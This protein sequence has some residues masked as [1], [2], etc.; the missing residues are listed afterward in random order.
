MNDLKEK[1]KNG[2]VFMEPSFCGLCHQRQYQ[3][4][5]GSS[6][7]YAAESP[8]FNT[9]E[10]VARRVLDGAVANNGRLKNFCNRCHTPIGEILG[11]LTDYVDDGSVTPMRNGLS[12]V[13]RRGIFCETCHRVSAIDTTHDFTAGRLGDGIA[14][15]S[16]I[17]EAT[18]RLRRGPL[19]DPVENVFHEVSAIAP[20]YMTGDRLCGACHDVR[21]GN[22][23]DTQT[24][25][26][27]QRLENLFTEFRSGPYA[28]L[29]HPRRPELEERHARL[30]GRVA[31]CQ[32]CHMSLYPVGEVGEYP[33]DYAALQGAGLAP[34]A[35]REVST[36]Y[37]TG[38]DIALVDFP[39]QDDETLDSHGMPRGLNQRRKLLLKRAVEMSV[40]ETPNAVVSGATFPLR[41]TLTNVGAGHRVVAGFSQERQIWIEARL[42]DAAS[43]ELF[44]T[45]YLCR[46]DPVRRTFD[47]DPDGDGEHDEDWADMGIAFSDDEYGTPAEPYLETPGPDKHLVT[48]TNRFEYIDAQGHPQH[49]HLPFPPT[50]HFNN[51]R[52][53]PP[54]EPVTVT[55]SIPIP[56][57]VASPLHLSVRLRFR[58]FPPNFLRYL[59]D[60][61]GSLVAE[62]T[63]DRVEIIDMAEAERKLDVIGSADL[64]GDGVVDHEDVLI[65]EEQWKEAMWGEPEGHQGP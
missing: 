65:F 60:R 61:Q 24:G 25:E 45:G 11:E 39:N 53:L 1:S 7:S 9:F 18:S 13:S 20:D 51:S 22:T 35:T 14:N 54:L 41:I 58:H 40:E 49:T 36:H 5:L 52:S 17:I 38:V 57:K 10:M 56:E 30:K 31:N 29:D 33:V 48:F 23:P 8:T 15:T 46:F 42:T 47:A 62:E 64:N 32:D 26:P 37:F 44:A 3:E 43:K 59:K 63:I 19:T 34:L 21:I 12:E 4:W 6:H 55:Y 50:N 2:V 16:L 27:F 28:K